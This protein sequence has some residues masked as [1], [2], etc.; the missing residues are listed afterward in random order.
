M[1][2]DFVDVVYPAYCNLPYEEIYRDLLEV[3]YRIYRQED[4]SLTIPNSEE[5]ILNL[6]H[7]GS[8]NAAV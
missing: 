8:V 7:N 2:E 3:T 1:P 5:Y 4:G 6:P